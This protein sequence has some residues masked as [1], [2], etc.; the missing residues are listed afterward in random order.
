[1]LKQG[2]W[3]VRTDVWSTPYKR[4]FLLL[5]FKTGLRRKG[6]ALS[7]GYIFGRRSLFCNA[8]LWT[9][10]AQHKGLDAEYGQKR[11]MRIWN[12]PSRSLWQQEPGKLIKSLIY[13]A[14]FL[15]VM[16]YFVL[17][18]QLQDIE[19]INISKVCVGIHGCVH[20]SWGLLKRS[21]GSNN[22]E[23]MGQIPNHSD[24]I[25]LHLDP[26]CSVL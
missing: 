18:N 8:P 9:T 11:A 10:I 23:V 2:E 16:G 19:K 17:F 4:H 13:I 22:A 6:H 25:L 3:V 15:E 26:I 5:L 1:M 12:H 7:G 14:T 21:R 20:N 24:F